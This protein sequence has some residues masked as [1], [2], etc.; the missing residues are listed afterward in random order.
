MVN[1]YPL[2]EIFPGELS[3]EKTEWL[4]LRGIKKESLFYFPLFPIDTSSQCIEYFS[5][6]SDH[7]FILRR[8]SIE[9]SLNVVSREV[10]PKIQQTKM[11]VPC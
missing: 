4:L 8:V 10:G 6:I 5:N 2:M 9:R 3:S 11:L 7:N 1:T